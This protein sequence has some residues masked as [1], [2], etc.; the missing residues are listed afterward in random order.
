MNTQTE[1]KEVTSQLFIRLN[2]LDSAIYNEED[3]EP[4]IYQDEEGNLIMYGN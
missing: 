1:D 3:G 2:L 4:Q